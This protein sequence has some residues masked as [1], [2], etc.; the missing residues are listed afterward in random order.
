MDKFGYE[1]DTDNT[2][3][4][5]EKGKCPICGAEL[6]GSPPICPEHGSEPFEKRTHDEEES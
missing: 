3:T 2:K 5:A 4:A 1:V 6:Q